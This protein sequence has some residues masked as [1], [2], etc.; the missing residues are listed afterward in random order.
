MSP[1]ASQL[2]TS[3]IQTGIIVLLAADKWVHK[4]TRSGP[5]LEVAIQSLKKTIDDGNERSSRKASELTVY[6]DQRREAFEQLRTE[7][8][9]IRGELMAMRGYRREDH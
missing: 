9:S 3:G 5:E 1:L 2:L 4:V 7:V 6:L 8:A